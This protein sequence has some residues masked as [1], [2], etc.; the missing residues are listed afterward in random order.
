MNSIG[1]VFGDTPNV[2]LRRAESLQ[3]DGLISIEW[4]GR[5]RLT[6]K[7]CERVRVDAATHLEAVVGDL[8]AAVTILREGAGGANWSYVSE[9]VRNLEG[10]LKRIAERV[11]RVEP[12]EEE[13]KKG[14][15]RSRAFME[16]LEEK[17]VEELA[18]LGVA[19]DL[20]RSAIDAV[21]RRIGIPR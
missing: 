3:M 5:I 9:D 12:G 16:R 14:V 2:V 21:R 20:A 10:E 4:G 13:L 1:T 7:G 17:H 19:L 6:Q 11:Q 18:S 15:E 8:V